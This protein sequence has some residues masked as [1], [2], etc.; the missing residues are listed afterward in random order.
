MDFYALVPAGKDGDSNVKTLKSRPPAH[1]QSAESLE[2]PADRVKHQGSGLTALGMIW[3][4]VMDALGTMRMTR[5]IW[6][7]RVR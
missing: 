1:W 7:C 2:H 5:L 3:Q 4:S 6:L